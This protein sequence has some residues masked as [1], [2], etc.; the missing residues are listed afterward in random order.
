MRRKLLLTICSVMISAVI[1]SV[2]S[3]SQPH[4]VAGSLP[5]SACE[6]LLIPGRLFASMFHDRGT[7]SPEFLWRSRVATFLLL[8]GIC[9]LILRKTATSIGG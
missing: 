8:A 1:V 3:A 7:A 2:V 6:F 5:D 9:Y 4:F